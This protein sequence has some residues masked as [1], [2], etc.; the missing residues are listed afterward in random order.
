RRADQVEQDKP[1]ERLLKPGVQLRKF[2]I[3]PQT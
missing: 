1:F 3:R 2:P